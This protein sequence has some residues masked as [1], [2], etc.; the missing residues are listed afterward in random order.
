MSS[1]QSTSI[2]VPYIYLSTAYTYSKY[3]YKMYVIADKSSIH[4]TAK[5]R[6]E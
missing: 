2:Y 4:K 3:V 5:E 1:C 6:M